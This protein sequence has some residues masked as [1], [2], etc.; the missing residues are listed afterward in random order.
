MMSQAEF[1]IITFHFEDEFDQ[2]DLKRVLDKS[3]DWIQ[4]MP[5]CVIV[6]TTSDA[7]KWTMRLKPIVEGK[8]NFF[9]CK[10]DISDRQG[11]LPK[12]VWSWLTDNAGRANAKIYITKKPSP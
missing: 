9:V 11:L 4:Y 8:G 2:D 1:F 12:W 7:S 5:N 10:L 3:L 6:K